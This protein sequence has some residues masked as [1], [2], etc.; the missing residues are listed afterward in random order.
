[1]EH[2]SE[3][4]IFSEFYKLT[5]EKCFGILASLL[6]I[7]TI[8]VYYSF[9]WYNINCS[10]KERSLINHLALCSV[11]CT[12][13]YNLLFSPAEIIIALFQPLDPWLC[14][15]YIVGRNI[16]SC[17]FMC[18]LGSISIVKYVY[19]FIYKNPVGAY[20]DFWCFF[21][22]SAILLWQV[23]FQTS[24]YIKDSKRPYLYYICT[25]SLPSDIP[26][27]SS[28]NY[29]LNGSFLLTILVYICVEFKV[30]MYKRQW[31]LR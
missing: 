31:R 4:T 5:P 13:P 28:F 30:K 14:G 1:M 10:N 24:M 7:L 16:I 27:N 2:K 17:H 21:I 8:P 22:N 25:N 6:N 15:F 19:I 29:P 9:Y 23:T 26:Q 3:S 11:L 12:V 20:D 18:L